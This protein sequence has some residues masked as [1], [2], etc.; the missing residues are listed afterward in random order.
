MLLVTIYQVQVTSKLIFLI[1]HIFYQR[2]IKKPFFGV[3]VRT[4]TQYIYACHLFSFLYHIELG[5]NSSVNNMFLH[6]YLIN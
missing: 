5:P 1:N 2:M 4:K 6:S 3:R